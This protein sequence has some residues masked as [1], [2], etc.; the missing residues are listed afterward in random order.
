MAKSHD[1]RA[2]RKRARRRMK[3]YWR[4]RER[5]RRAWSGWQQWVCSEMSRQVANDLDE[6]M[7]G[8]LLESA[9]G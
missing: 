1:N 5:M 7:L 9:N 4:A 2:K 6:Q 3:R 8:Q